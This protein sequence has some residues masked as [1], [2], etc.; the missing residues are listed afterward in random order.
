MIVSPSLLSAD[1]GHLANEIEMLNVSEAE[2]LHID[3]MDGVFVPNISFGFA[4]MKC[5]DQLS[6]KVMDAHL[7]IVEPQKYISE[8]KAAGGDIMT[9]HIEVCRDPKNVIEQIKASGMKVGIA[10]K[11]E[12]PVS[13][14]TDLINDLD[15]VCVMSVNPGFGGQKF[16]PDAIGK[17]KELKALIKEKGAKT[18][19]EVDGGINETTGRQAAE[20]GADVL[21][22][23]KYV[24]AAQNP[25]EAVS[26]L[27]RLS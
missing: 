18:L 8:V 15:M 22:A 17:V 19:I 16:I 23:G 6:D 26:S 7:M 14:L 1:F 25:L 10:I 13:V 3:I 20:A 24:F 5:I 21:V 9:V 2:Y 4:I 11:P 27:K 12:T